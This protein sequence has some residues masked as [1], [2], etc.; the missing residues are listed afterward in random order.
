MCWGGVVQG[1]ERGMVAD[2]PPPNK[3]ISTPRRDILGLSGYVL[4]QK[5]WLHSASHLVKKYM[6]FLY[7]VHVPENGD[8]DEP[9]AT[10]NKKSVGHK[11]P[12]GETACF[13]EIRSAGA[14]QDI[15]IYRVE[16]RH[17]GIWK[18]AWSPVTQRHLTGE[19]L[20]ADHS[21][22]WQGWSSST[23]V[24]FCHRSM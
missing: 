10:P 3:R 9:G 23:V 5:T 2:M 21:L 13:A 17:M 4:L 16:R 18:R 24:L 19:A 6:V 7:C 22:W 8:S 15:A 12:S 20:M 1:L 14:W 11:P